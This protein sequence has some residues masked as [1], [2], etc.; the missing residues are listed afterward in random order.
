MTTRYPSFSEV[1]KS[2]FH[3]IAFGFG[4]GLI[5]PA[6]GTWGTVSGLML[7]AALK[8]S[9]ISLLWLGVLCIVL[10][11]VG[12]VAA[13]ISAEK[14]GTHD[15][16]GIVI[17]EWL[18]IWMVLIIIPFNTIHWLVAFVL[19]RL[20]DILKPPPIGWIDKRVHGG[21]GIMLDDVIAALFAIASWW[22]L[23]SLA[24]LPL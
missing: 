9:D 16:P 21:L 19:F 11:V 4:S 2:P 13:H 22:L 14:L 7:F 18:G 8:F 3:F 12:T 23:T 1:V 10:A 6:P 15:H 24:L 5:R 20:F 17:D